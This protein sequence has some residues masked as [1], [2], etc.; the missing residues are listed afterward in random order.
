MDH[1]QLLEGRDTLGDLLGEAELG[2]LGVGILSPELVVVE[3]ELVE[4]RSESA[5]EHAEHLFSVR[6]Y[7]VWHSGSYIRSRTDSI[8]ELPLVGSKQIG[9]D[10]L[11][12]VETVSQAVSL[13]ERSTDLSEGDTNQAVRKFLQLLFD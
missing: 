4:Q 11:D 5:S 6:C 9:E 3:L 10:T 7:P 1:D 8:E 12:K 2:L 13:E